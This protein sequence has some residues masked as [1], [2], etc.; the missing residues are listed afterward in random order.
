MFY[1]VFYSVKPENILINEIGYAVLTDFGLC[2]ENVS[3][4]TGAYTVCGT[5]EYLAP[6]ILI[7]RKYGIAADWWSFG[8]LLFEMVVG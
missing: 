4:L 8:V 3:T 7:N 5:P 1:I 6:E 2:K